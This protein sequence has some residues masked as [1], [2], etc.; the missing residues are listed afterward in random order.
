MDSSK[1]S[2]D[3][4]KK[5]ATKQ[6]GQKIEQKAA[7]LDEV[8]ALQKQNTDFQKPDQINQFKEQANV[9]KYQEQFNKQQL[10]L[11]N[12][13]VANNALLAK[14]EIVK[15]AQNKIRKYKNS[16][17]LVKSGK[18][19][20]EDKED[21]LKDKPQKRIIYGSNFQMNP[22]D[23]FAVDISPLLGYRFTKRWSVALGGSFRYSVD[24]DN[25]YK[26]EFGEDMAYGFRTFSQYK[27]LSSFFIHSEWERFYAP[28]MSNGLL[29]GLGKQFSITRGIK[30]NISILY[31]FLYDKND[32]PHNQAFVIRFGLSNQ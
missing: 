11:K 16:Y 27:I 21:P 23:P 1:F 7:N 14:G 10:N 31:D 13:L 6:M 32:S 24:Q 22:G 9:D 30:G 2:V 29:A 26:P 18:N 25:N 15:S 5:V 17:K 28:V 20:A 3:S 4:L 12:Q 19:V 8:K